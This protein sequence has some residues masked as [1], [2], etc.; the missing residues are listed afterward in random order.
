MKFTQFVRDYLANNKDSNL[1]YREAMKDDG[2]RCAYKQYE[3]DL[4]KKGII[5]KT[6]KRPEPKR[7]Y[8]KKSDCSSCNV[9]INNVPA[10]SSSYSPPSSPKSKQPDLPP[11]P[12]PQTPQQ[13][14]PQQPLSQAQAQ[15]QEFYMENPLLAPRPKK[16]VPQEVS[17]GRDEDEDLSYLSFNPTAPPPSVASTNINTD[18]LI[19]EEI[20]NLSEE[21]IKQVNEDLQRYENDPAYNKSVKEKIR[22]IEESTGSAPKSEPKVENFVPRTQLFSP[23]FSSGPLQGRMETERDLAPIPATSDFGE[24]MRGEQ[25][26]DK[27]RKDFGLSKRIEKSTGPMGT[28]KKKSTASA[29]AAD[30]QRYVLLP[31]QRNTEEPRKPLP[32]M[33]ANVTLEDVPDKEPYDIIDE[34]ETI[35]GDIADAVLLEVVQELGIGK[36]SSFKKEKRKVL[37]NSDFSALPKAIMEHLE[38]KKREEEYNRTATP[39]YEIYEKYKDVL[40][41][42]MERIADDARYAHAKKTERNLRRKEAAVERRNLKGV[43]EPVV[44]SGR[45]KIK[46]K[47]PKPGPAFGTKEYRK[48]LRKS[49]VDGVRERNEKRKHNSRTVDKKELLPRR[50]RLTGPTVGI[51]SWEP[52]DD[53][54][55]RG[56]RP[57]S[58]NGLDRNQK[59]KDLFSAILD[60]L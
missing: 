52:E 1:T 18:S 44:R 38:E 33:S 30:E 2:V 29:S 16:K 36:E 5:R 22:K 9:V 41:L 8:N 28:P 34:A 49:I 60:V 56:I 23:R 27:L 37:K 14:A 40:K 7:R 11:P 39:E 54:P 15:S 25:A 3:A 19:A 57:I 48:M 6:E 51:D 45:S 17:V 10:S 24:E 50:K 46:K 13:T 20:D 59:I 26:L 53:T 35:I 42:A 12:P 55:R 32:L 4:C 58:G 21:E 31:E 47:K 43:M